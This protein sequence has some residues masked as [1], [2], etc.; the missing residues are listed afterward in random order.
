MNPIVFALRRPYTVMVGV[1]AVLVGAALAAYRSKVDIF[2]PLNTPV[3]YVCQPYGGMN[4]QQMEGLLT[5]YYEY[6]FLYV[7]GVE[8]VESKNIQGMTLIKLY[9]HPGTNMGEAMAETVA[10]VNRSRFMMPPGTVPPFV[11][12]LDTGSA[13]IGYLVLN[14]DKLSIKEIQDIATMRVRPMFSNVPGISTPPAFGGNQRAVVVSVDPDRLHDQHLTLDQITQAVADGN[15]VAPSG[16]VRLDDRTWLVNSNVMVGANPVAE[17]GQIPVRLGANPLLLRDVATITDGSD[18]TAGYALVNGRRS[19]YMLVMKRS[20]AS[21]ISVVNELHK[22]LPKMRDAAPEVDIQFAFDQS[23]IVTQAMTGVAAEGLTGAVL[24]GLMVLLFLRDW[25]SVIVVVLNIPIALLASVFG[26][27][28]C[29]QTVNL[30]TLGGLALAVGILVDEATV[31]V[32]N[33]HTQME[34]T[35][36]VARAVRAGNAG[37]GR[38]ATARHAVRAGRVRAVVLHDRGGPRAVRPAVAGRRVRHDRQLHPEQHVRAGAVRVAAEA[39]AAPRAG[40]AAAGRAVVRAGAGAGGGVAVGADA[41]VPAA[42]RR[43]GVGAVRRTRHGRVPAGRQGGVPTAD[44]GPHRHPHRAD[45]GTGAAGAADHRARGRRAR[46]GEDDRRVRRLVPHQLPDPGRPP[47]D[48]RAG[49]G[50]GEGG[51]D[52]RGGAGRGVQGPAAGGAGTP[53]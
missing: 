30:M 24:T 36:S 31:E 28:V 32:E 1:L 12:R 43:R 38:A 10:A 7:N 49:G 37:N 13:S 23:P 34:R 19:V 17:L 29:G 48:R 40:P 50:A 5:T 41:G 46:P 2:P 45:G 42:G 18:I 25:R 16:N 35:D 47:V 4:P 3:I 27:W 22:A 11:T 26:L 44:E 52:R 8:H 21:T 15:A 9:F 53:S 20:D 14:S 6:H 33:I 51:P 39:A